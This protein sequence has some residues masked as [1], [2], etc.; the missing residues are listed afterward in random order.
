MRMGASMGVSKPV[1]PSVRRLPRPR[2]TPARGT[3]LRRRS[4]TR[5]EAPEGGEA[6]PSPCSVGLPSLPGRRRLHRAG[7][8]GRRAEAR[9]ALL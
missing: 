2:A 3:G 6:V 1:V 9:G 4:P 8:L 5:A 7:A